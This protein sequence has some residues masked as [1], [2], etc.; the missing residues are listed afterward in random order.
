M[1]NILSV[2]EPIFQINYIV[3][4]QLSNKGVSGEYTMIFNNVASVFKNVSMPQEDKL[5]DDGSNNLF[6]I[7]GDP[8]GMPIYKNLKNKVL[9]S[10]YY[11]GKKSNKCI[12][13]DTLPKINWKILKE[14]KKISNITAQKAIGSFGG[15]MYNVWFAPSISNQHGP[16]YLYGLPG[17]ILEAKSLDNKINIAFKSLKKLQQ[18]NEVQT[19]S[20]T[21]KAQCVA[22]AEYKIK[23]DQVYKK[24][25]IEVE[26]RGGHFV[27]DTAI[28]SQIWKG[29]L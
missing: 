20:K 19:L 28:D 23:R 29:Y 26:S 14:T 25:Q 24:I 21:I 11:I 10:K 27:R 6:V 17:L 3:S 2:N 4:S 9:E 22:H 7:S 5:I 12:V 16:F 1:Y 8:D 13:Q 15:R 18:I